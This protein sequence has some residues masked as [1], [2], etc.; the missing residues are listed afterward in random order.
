MTASAPPKGPSPR[1]PGA[2]ASR[3]SVLRTLALAAA[4][5]FLSPARAQSE[6][7]IEIGFMGLHHRGAHLLQAF[8]DTR[9]VLVTWLCDVDQRAVE[10][11]GKT[12]AARQTRPFKVTPDLRRMLE[13]RR[14]QALVIAT[15]DH[16]HGPAAI[17]AAQA[18][19]HVF[20][21]SPLAHN[22]REGE[23]LIEAFRRSRTTF[24][25]GLQRRSLPWVIEAIGHLHQGA[26]GPIHFAR[27]WH[28]GRRGSIGFG[29][30]AP[31]PSWLDYALW[32]GP[33][34]D[35]VFRDNVVHDHW[36][37]FWH[38]GTGELGAQVGRLDLARWGLNVDCPSRVTS[39]GGRYF[40]E[41]DQETPDTQVVAFQFGDR[42]LTWE[43]RSCLPETSEGTSAGI[44]FFGS[45]GTL[46][47]HD[48]GY[49]LLDADGRESRRVDGDLA[50]GTALHV[51][52]FLDGIV[53]PARTPNATVREAH[54][55][56]LL[57]HLGN[58]AYRSGGALEVNPETQQL[59]NDPTAAAYWSRDYR[60]DWR[61]RV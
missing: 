4:G 41:D 61:P 16:W 20:L 45:R 52:R 1:V 6:D 36:R 51:Q 57:C 26:L 12:V 55:S 22:P 11:A 31:V 30:F 21:E 37:W 60:A 42:T 8:L 35:R 40:F 14:L 15:P 19:K 34:P 49:R 2:A 27:A 7:R 28:A 38:W 3:R 44:T 53:H 50:A 10:S 33:A 46:H 47:L 48:R 39:V 24:Q 9:R 43:H 58:I 25:A 32:Q 5:P 56:T 54:L 17:L 29:Q 13:D 59:R 18:G 23:W